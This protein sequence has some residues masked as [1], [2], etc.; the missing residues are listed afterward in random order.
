MNGEKLLAIRNPIIIITSTLSVSLKESKINALNEKTTKANF[1]TISF[2]DKSS[3]LVS[4]EKNLNLKNS[5]QCATEYLN[6]SKLYLATNNSNTDSSTYLNTIN[7]CSLRSPKLNN[8]NL[9][10]KSGFINSNILNSISTRHYSKNNSKQKNLGNKNI[11]SNNYENNFICKTETSEKIEEKIFQKKVFAFSKNKSSTGRNLRNFNKKIM[12]QKSPISHLMP[13]IKNSRDEIKNKSNN[14]YSKGENKDNLLSNLIK[15]TFKNSLNVSKQKENRKNSHKNFSKKSA[16]SKNLMLQNS[17]K[18]K[19]YNGKAIPSINNLIQENTKC[20]VKNTKDNNINTQVKLI[21]INGMKKNNNSQY[22]NFMIDNKIFKTKLNFNHSLN[23][24]KDKAN[25]KFSTIETSKSKYNKISTNKLHLNIVFNKQIMSGSKYP[26]IENSKEKSA[27]QFNQLSEIN[28][29]NFN[30]IETSKDFIQ[31][32]HSTNK[33]LSNK[34]NSLSNYTNSTSTKKFVFKKTNKENQKNILIF[35]SDFE[36]E[37]NSPIINNKNFLFKTSTN[38]YDYPKAQISHL[39]L[40]Q[41]NYN[42][43]FLS[44]DLNSKYLNEKDENLFSDESKI[45]QKDECLI[46]NRKIGINNNNMKIN[47]NPFSKTEDN[48]RFKIISNLNDNIEKNENKNKISNKEQLENNFKI[49]V[50]NNNKKFYINRRKNNY[51]HNQFDDSLISENNK[52]FSFRKHENKFTTLENL[53][54]SVMENHFKVAKRI[55]YYLN[56]S[57]DDLNDDNNEKN[58]VNA[59]KFAFTPYLNKNSAENININSN[60]I[61]NFNENKHLSETEKFGL[62]ERLKKLGQKYDNLNKEPQAEFS[63]KITNKPEIFALSNLNN[64]LNNKN[65]NELF[66]ILSTNIQEIN[67]LISSENY[68]NFNKNPNKLRNK[69]LKIKENTIMHSSNKKNICGNNPKDSE[70][71]SNLV[72]FI[73][74]KSSFV[75]SNEIRRNLNFQDSNLI[76]NFNLDKNQNLLISKN[77]NRIFSNDKS[78]LFSDSLSLNYNEFSVHNLNSNQIEN[79]LDKTEADRFKNLIN[80]GNICTNTTEIL[81]NFIT[82]KNLISENFDKKNENCELEKLNKKKYTKSINNFNEILNYDTDSLLFIQ[83]NNYEYNIKNNQ[84][85]IFENDLRDSREFMI[86]N[87]IDNHIKNKNSFMN[88]HSSNNFYNK[89]KKGNVV[90]C[91]EKEFILDSYQYNRNEMETDIGIYCKTEADCKINKYSKVNVKENKFEE[92]L[93]QQKNDMNLSINQNLNN[94]KFN[95]NSKLDITECQYGVDINN[96]NKQDC[97]YFDI[98]EAKDFQIDKDNDSNKHKNI[99]SNNKT[100]RNGLCTVQKDKNNNCVLI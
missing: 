95:I 1:P 55:D 82:N 14:L 67:N 40:D 16:Q 57:P 69:N 51:D 35:N 59:N 38:N 4:K 34:G 85:L 90:N 63:G 87:V 86:N 27:K 21:S 12:P 72:N 41:N 29:E 77:H 73:D 36:N 89:N 9:I 76:S 79:P 26:N 80:G 91:Y 84:K 2:N 22:N 47:E 58:S 6:L 100:Q 96:I 49:D 93:F 61:Y 70:Q 39:P 99:S 54:K 3:N 78:Q 75:F 5:K 19:E 24:S 68:T 32:F 11:F 64:N 15:K 33:K 48:L 13:Y 23:G 81:N 10:G 37:N 88:F 66:N 60:K 8:N 20:V 83:N 46:T 31:N 44:S 92:K 56:C 94:N 97:D 50:N 65:Y 17:N 43:S 28:Y 42:V 45:T 53:K 7:T 30:T 18:I 98:R 25:K 62:T 71:I 52:D 74:N